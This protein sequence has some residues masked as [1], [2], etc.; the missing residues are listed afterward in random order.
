[1]YSQRC[2][3]NWVKAD[4]PRDSR[5]YLKDESGRKYVEYFAKVSGVNFT[6]M[7]DAGIKFYACVQYPNGQEVCTNTAL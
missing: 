2:N 3:A 6:D 1:M 7:R 4:V 5:L